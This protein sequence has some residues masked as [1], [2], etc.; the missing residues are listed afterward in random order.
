MPEKLANLEL[1][2]S[3]LTELQIVPDMH[4]RKAAMADRAD[5]FVLYRG[6]R[7]GKLF[8]VWTWTQLGCSSKALGRHECGWLLRLV[9]WVLGSS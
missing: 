9:A 8:E 6:R 4:A 7:D 5:A 3:G 2:H 1:P